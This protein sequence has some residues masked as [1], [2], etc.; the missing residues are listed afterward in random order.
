MP[1]L[2]VGHPSEEIGVIVCRAYDGDVAV[3]RHATAVRE[4]LDFSLLS[5][6]YDTTLLCNIVLPLFFIRFLK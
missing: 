4:A 1:D 2:E 3:E 6:S 5:S